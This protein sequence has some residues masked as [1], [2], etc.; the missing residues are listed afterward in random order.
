MVISDHD[1]LAICK[2][3]RLHE[4]GFYLLAHSREVSSRRQH[5]VV[6]IFGLII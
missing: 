6:I 4:L 3:D 1:P 2:E 5:G